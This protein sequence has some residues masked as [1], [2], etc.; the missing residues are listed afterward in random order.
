MKKII[1]I[2]LIS[3]ILIQTSSIGFDDI[4]KVKNLYEHARYHYETYGDSF[5][6]FLAEHY[7]DEMASHQ[8]EHKEHQKL[9][10]KHMDNCLQHHVSFT[11]NDIQFNL[12]CDC[13]IHI[14]S[15]YFYKE[16]VSSFE[17][18]P[19]FQPPKTA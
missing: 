13:I 19:V 6:E 15:N 7:G 4:L 12:N 16:L 11:F 8:N 2:L 9:P 10:L 14:N 17:N 3:L 1:S 5:F 18:S